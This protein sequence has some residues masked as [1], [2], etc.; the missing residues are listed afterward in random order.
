MQKN[1][2]EYRMNERIKRTKEVRKDLSGDSD[3]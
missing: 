1:I 3:E 2:E